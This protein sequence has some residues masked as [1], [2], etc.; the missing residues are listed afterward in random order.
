MKKYNS[1]ILFIFF[2]VLIDIIGMA[3]IIPVMP[4]LIQ[5]L[6]H[7]D[8]SEASKYGSWLLFSYAAMQFLFSP[9]VG[10]LSDRYGRRP[11][12]LLSLLGMCLNYVILIF[13]PSFGWLLLGRFLMGVFGASIS[14]ANAYI[15]DVSAP[16]KRTQNFGLI[17]VAFGLGFIIGPV[18]GGLASDI[19]SRAPFVVAAILTLINLLYGY[20]VLPESL[21]PENRRPFD[22][23][24]ANPVNSLL[25]LRKHPV[26]SQLAVALFC[27]YIASHAVQ[28][29]WPYYTQYKF[30]WDD[31]TIGISLAVV[32]LLSM[33]VSGIIIRWTLKYWGNVNSILIGF[34][35]YAVGLVCFAFAGKGW[36]MF[37][38]LVPYCM[39]MIVGPSLQGIMSNQTPPDKQG[40]LQGAITSVMSIATVFGPL[41]MLNLFNHFSGTNAIYEFPGI[42]FITGLLF[43]VLATVSLLPYLKKIRKTEETDKAI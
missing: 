34:L 24:R 13:A 9:V 27:L 36:M 28:S 21:K 43:M 14:T 1:A 10:G 40:E 23:S 35:F 31:K 25:N 39:G 7:G 30:G 16:E 12:L 2:T 18:I 37:A 20:F 42:P 33:L 26:V 22:W 15:A 4:T 17:G 38:A 11:I 3:V 32:G 29:T 41:L 19:S 5:E 6:I 8:V